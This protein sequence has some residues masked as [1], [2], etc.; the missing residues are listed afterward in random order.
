MHDIAVIFK[1]NSPG[2]FNIVLLCKLVNLGLLDIKS[3]SPEDYLKFVVADLIGLMGVEQ[4]KCFP[5]FLFL[6]F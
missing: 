3:E 4:R 1:V 5:N 2:F 6:I